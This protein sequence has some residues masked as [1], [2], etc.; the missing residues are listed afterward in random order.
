MWRPES[1][2]NYIQDMTGV[3]YNKLLTSTENAYFYFLF[4]LLFRRRFTVCGSPLNVK[5]KSTNE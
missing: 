1:R 4:F 2:I 3:N 5:F